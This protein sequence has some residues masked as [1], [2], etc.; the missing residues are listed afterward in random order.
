MKAH[1]QKKGIETFGVRIDGTYDYPKEQF[2]KV[3]YPPLILY[4]QG[5]WGLALTGRGICVVGTRNPSTEGKKRAKRLVE[6]LVQH[7][8][9]IFSG[10]AKGIDSVAH[11]TAIENRGK[12]VAVIGTP[13][14]QVY[15]KENAG[16]QK[17]IA[18]KHLL[19]SQVPVIR[20][21]KSDPKQSRFH[22]P[23]RNKIMSA[24]SEATVIVEAGE[25]SGTLVQAKAAL[26]QGRKLFILNSCFENPS[27]TWPSK[28]ESKGAIRVKSTEDIF[29]T[30]T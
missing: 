24:L 16:L 18:E 20:Y 11:R 5:F 26:D 1:L 15:P 13:L 22:F 28:L 4:F 30:F 7:N 14:S 17:E 23:E 6:E 10:L 25:T 21:T 3:K 29:R 12:T 19:I 9:T 2:L 8:F 27:L